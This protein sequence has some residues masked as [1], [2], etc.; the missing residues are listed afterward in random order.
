[1]ISLVYMPPSLPRK[2][3]SDKILKTQMHTHTSVE[4]AASTCNGAMPA[5]LKSRGGSFTLATCCD[6]CFV[7]KRCFAKDERKLGGASKNLAELST[8]T[9]TAFEEWLER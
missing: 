3:H 7:P 1:M 5:V 4:L 6:E 9:L 8:G 2:E